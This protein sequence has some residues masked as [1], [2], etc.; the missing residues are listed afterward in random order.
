MG[1][2]NSYIK[3]IRIP[4]WYIVLLP[5][6]IGFAITA[7]NYS[8]LRIGTIIYT[9][10]SL[11]AT[12]SFTLAI[13]FYSD[14]EVDR[15]H[16]GG[17]KDVDIRTQPFVTE[18]ISRGE[19][20][21]ILLLLLTCSL[22]GFLVNLR[23]GIIVF[24]FLILGIIYSIPPFR[25]KGRPFLDILVNVSGLTLSFILGMNIQD[26]IVPQLSLL[27]W[28]IFGVANSYLLLA[29]SD[30]KF[31][32]KVGIMTTAVY[33]GIKKSLKLWRVFWF[34]GKLIE[35]IILVSPIDILIKI[36]IL[37]KILIYAD[38]YYW[39]IKGD[40]SKFIGTTIRK[41]ML[42]EVI[43]S[44]LGILGLL[45]IGILRYYGLSPI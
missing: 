11:I 8:N 39:I 18:A 44:Y 38:D 42:Q 26:L 29:I 17:K 27:L 15:L 1:K 10:L 9:I 35:L 19:A 21:P 33:L 34:F 25:F 31:D 22:T 6:S 2:L 43:Y 3:L 13:N 14:K 20:I 23:Y 16:D 45:L 4:A 24:V 40:L 36:M 5:F 41:D 28:F 30:F 7:F 37:L 12:W 32:K